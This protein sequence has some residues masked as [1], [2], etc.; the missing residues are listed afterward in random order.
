MGG[1]Y[2]TSQ[3]SYPP[4]CKQGADGCA[5]P[6]PPAQPEHNF[7]FHNVSTS[8][9]YVIEHWPASVPIVFLGW[10][11]GGAIMTGGSMS[12]KTPEQNPCRRAYI[13]HQGGPNKDRQSWD[14][15]TTLFAVRGAAAFKGVYTIHGAGG[16]N[17][18]DDSDGTNAWSA[19]NPQQRKQSY[20][21]L[22]GM[23]AEARAK[24]ARAVKDAIDD[25]L[26]RKPKRQRRPLKTTDADAI[27]VSKS[28]LWRDQDPT[29]GVC[30]TKAAG[31]DCAGKTCSSGPSDCYCSCGYHAYGGPQLAVTK[32]GTLLSIVE[33][34]K[35][36]VDGGDEGAGGHKAWHDIL[37]K[38]STDSGNTWSNATVVYSESGGWGK[39]A[40]TANSTIGNGELVADLETGEIFVFMCRNNSQVLLASSKDDAVTF[41]VAK[42]VTK[43]VKPDSLQW[44]WYATSFSSVQ[45]RFNK[46]HNGRLV[47]CADHVLHG[48]AAYPIANSHSHTVTSDDHGKT[49]RVGK[50]VL[51][52]NTSN[53]CS[54]AELA[55]GTVV[56]NSRNYVGEATHGVHR[57]ISHS[58][59]GGDS[60]PVGWFAQDLP[61]P[62]VF[63]DITSTADGKTLLLTHP[64]SAYV[65][66]PAVDS[67]SNLCCSS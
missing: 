18:V 59:D 2:P 52:L 36:A 35:H 49:W 38:R 7:G 12:S 27:I 55:N 15:A 42:D 47:A 19:S 40:G 13:D 51:A 44:G 5:P 61:D 28:K 32:A 53:E 21:E 25:L 4:G 9:A 45:L 22:A 50:T 30:A 65:R 48:F 1:R 17:V 58:H 64:N 62:I 37:I 54:V 63:S 11:V 46:K 24:S 66:I 10:G 56:M 16:N 43:Q 41:A 3:S 34:R 57:Y 29:D 60:F 6:W 31:F 23:D 8:T 39:A 20:L 26:T 67:L 33:G 14:P